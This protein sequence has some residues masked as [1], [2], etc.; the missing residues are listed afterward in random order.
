MRA[1]ARGAYW[2]LDYWQIWDQDGDTSD[3]RQQTAWRNFVNPWG[4]TVFTVSEVST[5]ILLPSVDLKVSLNFCLDRKVML[6]SVTS[7]Y[8]SRPGT[9]C[10]VMLWPASL[11]SWEH[12]NIVTRPT[13]HCAILQHKCIV[14]SLLWSSASTSLYPNMRRFD[15]SSVRWIWMNVNEPELCLKAILYKSFDRMR[16]TFASVMRGLKEVRVESW[17]GKSWC[18]WDLGSKWYLRGWC[19]RNI[20]FPHNITHSHNVIITRVTNYYHQTQ[21]ENL[22]CQQN[23]N[24]YF[25]WFKFSKVTSSGLVNSFKSKRCEDSPIC[26]S[27]FPI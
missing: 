15:S 2:P 13:R 27:D 8:A 20:Y 1:D 7:Y 23:N 19:C 18:E 12:Y 9:Q 5:S 17:E 25:R 26:F 14:G 21:T 24:I 3:N 16:I 4:R 6:I 10:M 22:N 11:Q